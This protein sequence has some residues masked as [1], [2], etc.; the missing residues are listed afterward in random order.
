[1]SLSDLGTPCAAT[2]TAIPMLLLDLKSLCCYQCCIS[3]V[4]I[5][6]SCWCPI[7]PP[8]SFVSSVRLNVTHLCSVSF[9][10][11]HPVSLPSVHPSCCYPVCASC[12][13][14]QVAYT[15]FATPMSLHSLHLY[16][17]TSSATIVLVLA[18]CPCFQVCSL[19]L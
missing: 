18:L 6:T 3:Q 14:T 7:C 16:V 17:I 12:V 2:Q 5:C 9:L 10:D 1:M 8:P 19:S 15:K 13:V 4:S 11:L